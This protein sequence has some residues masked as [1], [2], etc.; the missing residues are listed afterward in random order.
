MINTDDEKKEISTVDENAEE[1][2]VESKVE[3]ETEEKVEEEVKLDDY[4][5][6]EKKQIKISLKTFIYFFAIVILIGALYLLICLIDR[7]LV[8]IANYYDETDSSYV[9]EAEPVDKEGVILQYHYNENVVII[10]E[11]IGSEVRK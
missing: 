7:C 11:Y 5:Q 9:L 6:L 4:I 3:E 8:G 2:E 1:A 10:D